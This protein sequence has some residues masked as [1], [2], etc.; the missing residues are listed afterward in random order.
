MIDRSR[1]WRR[2]KARQTTEHVKETKNWLKRQFA[3]LKPEK[4]YLDKAEKKRHKPGKLTHV[5][6]MRLGWRLNGELKD[7]FSS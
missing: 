7:E 3:K 2:K 4:G 5:Q 6:D 1:A